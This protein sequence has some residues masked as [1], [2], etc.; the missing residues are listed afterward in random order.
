LPKVYKDTYPSDIEL[1]AGWYMF[2]WTWTL[3]N[4]CVLHSCCFEVKRGLANFSKL[5]DKAFPNHWL[6][7][8][9]LTTKLA[10]FVL[11]ILAEFFH[12]WL[13]YIIG[14]EFH[15][16]LLSSFNFLIMN[17]SYPTV[18]LFVVCIVRSP[19]WRQ[20]VVY[21]TQNGTLQFVLNYACH[22]IID[23]IITDNTK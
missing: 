23:K 3:Y 15:E 6:L 9:F 17:L 5:F 7:M 4:A 2:S 19:K 11:C 13:F 20:V 16:S 18:C 21:H 22:T 14:T 12:V 10:H 1:L 8:I